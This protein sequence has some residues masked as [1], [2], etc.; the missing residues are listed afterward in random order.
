[1]LLIRPVQADPSDSFR[2]EGKH[3]FV[4]FLSQE[5]GEHAC[6]ELAIGL[7]SG[8]RRNDNI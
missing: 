4:F 5:I 3:G 1:M 7:V 2:N 8:G 6:W